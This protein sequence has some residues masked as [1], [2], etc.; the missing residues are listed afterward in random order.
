MMMIKRKIFRISAG[1][2]LAGLS[3]VGAAYASQASLTV[4]PNTGLANIQIVSVSGS[5]FGPNST[6]DIQE[7]QGLG[8][9]P[10]K[11]VWCPGSQVQA[12]SDSNGNWGPVDFTVHRTFTA[13]NGAGSSQ[14]ITCGQTNECAV[15]ANNRTG[16]LKYTWTNV[17]FAN[18]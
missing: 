10:Q 14:T 15:Y 16:P 1:A 3:I 11:D 5:N 13:T 18:P 17:S 8:G 7:C 9:N 4:T 6:I 2:L 12:T